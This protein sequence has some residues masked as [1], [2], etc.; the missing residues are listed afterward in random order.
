[1]PKGQEVPE[2]IT[3]PEAGVKGSYFENSLIV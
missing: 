3:A 1:M 2:I